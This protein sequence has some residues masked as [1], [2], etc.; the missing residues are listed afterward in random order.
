MVD[1]ISVFHREQKSIANELITFAA[2]LF[3]CS[4]AYAATTGTISAGV[5]GLWAITLYFSSTIFTVKLRK[6]KPVPHQGWCTTRSPRWLS[7]PHWLVISS[8]S[9]SL[10]VALLKFGIVAS[11]QQWYKRAKI[12]LV[13]MLET[14]A[15]FCFL[16]IVALSVLPA[17]LTTL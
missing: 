17:H 9:S 5:I 4:L 7:S 2:A 12:Q 10:W 16:T 15:A 3:I 14:G 11:N 6:P 1:A 13:A 8:H